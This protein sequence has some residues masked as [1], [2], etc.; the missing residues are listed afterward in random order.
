M[1]KPKEIYEI[2]KVSFHVHIFIYLCIVCFNDTFKWSE[3]DIY[4]RVF[5][6]VVSTIITLLIVVPNDNPKS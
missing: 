5:W 2:F 6:H 1:T 4:T 3:W